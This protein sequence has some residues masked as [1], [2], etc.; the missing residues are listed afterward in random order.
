[1]NRTKLG[2]ALMLS[3]AMAPAMS[4]AET[5]KIGIL[6]TTSGPPAVLGEHARDGA[7]LAAEQLGMVGGMETEILVVDAE[8]KPD[9]A[10]QKARELV[11]R[12]E[13][14]FV[15]GPIFSNV[16][17]A[18]AG[19]VTESAFLLSPN[20]GPSV[21]AGEGC[22]PNLFVV[23]YQNDQMPTVIAKHMNDEGI[24]DAFILAPNYQA[25][26]DSLNGF[27]SVFEG[28]VT[29]ELYVQLGQL[30]YQAELAQ[31]AAMQPSA[32]YAFL[33]GG[34]GVNFVKQY[35]QAGLKSIPLMTAFTVDETTLPAEQDAA[36]GM[37]SGTNWS[38]SLDVPESLA[39]VEAFEAKY[40]YVPALYAAGGYDAMMLIDSAVKK[41]GSLDDMDAL[42]AALE[43]ADFASV[44]GKF[45]FSPNH[46]PIQN[47]YLAEAVQRE[48][49]K[50]AT[51]IVE[52]VWEDY[53]DTYVDQCKM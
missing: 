1:M 9:V 45:S 4:A 53:A 25:G 5:L 31:I 24:G 52:T 12:D 21:F 44:R 48:D 11:E 16:M 19:P 23:A 39:F 14:D 22:D 26:K 30:D 40:D 29:S 50:Y 32:V 49:G 36:L 3:V 47:F 13:V 6:T 7:L 43:E 2:A 10:A 38:P 15:I 51:Q 46:F 18:I 42:R 8:G 37:L 34:M 33:P 35:D 27:K 20:A 41:V 28:T 17:G